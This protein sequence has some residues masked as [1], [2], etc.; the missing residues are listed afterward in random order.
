MIKYK[1]RDKQE[2]NDE[3]TCW[4]EKDDR[5]QICLIAKN[6]DHIEKILTLTDKGGLLTHTLAADSSFEK[7]DSGEI[8][9]E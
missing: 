4:L 7:D 5:G 1:I 2:E 3:I 8:I 6:D 9:I